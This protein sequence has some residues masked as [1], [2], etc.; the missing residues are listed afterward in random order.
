MSNYF[1]LSQIFIE[2]Y[3]HY[4]VKWPIEIEADGSIVPGLIAGEG[5]HFMIPRQ[6]QLELKWVFDAVEIGRSAESPVSLDL[7]YNPVSGKVC[8][9][10]YS[11]WATAFEQLGTEVWLHQWMVESADRVRNEIGAAL[12]NRDVITRHFNGPVEVRPVGTPEYV[13]L[14]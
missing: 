1:A 4:G 10:D 12:Q 9:D 8:F 3:T 11:R 14:Q 13:V 5:T 2:H 6:G 7:E